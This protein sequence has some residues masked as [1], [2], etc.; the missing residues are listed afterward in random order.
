MHALDAL[1]EVVRICD[2]VIS[3][4]AGSTVTERHKPLSTTFFQVIIR[5]SHLEVATVCL[6][7]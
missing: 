5:L 1:Q 6:C 7:K 2:D 3:G 4:A